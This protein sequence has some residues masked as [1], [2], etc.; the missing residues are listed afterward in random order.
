MTR[1]VGGAARGRRLRVSATGTRPTSDRAREAVFSSLESQRGGLS[2]SWV[3][4]L[5]AGSGA[6]GLEAL[7]RGAAGVDL[8]ER[9]RGAL[10]AIE[11]NVESLSLPGAHVHRA[12]VEQWVQGRTQVS[13]PPQSADVVFVDPP[14]DVP[15]EDLADVLAALGESGRIAPG[16]W[17]V[18]ERSRRAD[19]FSWP[20]GFS[21]DRH[22]RYGEAV[23]WFG[24]FDSVATC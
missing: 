18:V 14:Y 3:I 15:A 23:L 2:G 19:D 8:V 21:A 6:M 22:R 20:T 5:Y 13:Q 24:R 4:D 11:A 7:S 16:A 9:D 1:I 17:V 10:A 12:D